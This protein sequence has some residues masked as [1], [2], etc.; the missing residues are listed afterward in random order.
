[1][2]VM[3]Q[4]RNELTEHWSRKPKRTRKRVPVLGVKI[5]DG[6]AIKQLPPGRAYGADGLRARKKPKPQALSKRA[7]KLKRK[8]RANTR[9]DAASYQAKTRHV[10]LADLCERRDHRKRAQP[11]AL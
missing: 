8:D 6:V 11:G 1:M 9:A 2:P 4:H 10:A 5:E 3:S 7:M